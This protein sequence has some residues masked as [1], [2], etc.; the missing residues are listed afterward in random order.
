MTRVMYNDGLHDHKTGKTGLG[1]DI[2][3]QHDISTRHTENAS[4]FTVKLVAITTAL[5]EQSKMKRD[6][7]LI[8]TDSLSAIT[9]VN[10]TSGLRTDVTYETYKET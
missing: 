1:V 10:N 8:I 7:V 4:K 3:H 5:T 9:P 2:T 6:K